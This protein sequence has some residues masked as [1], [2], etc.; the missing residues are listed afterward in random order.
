MLRVAQGRS[1]RA[2]LTD[3]RRSARL[4]SGPY[5]DHRRAAKFSALLFVAREHRFVER[6]L[7]LLAGGARCL[8]QARQGVAASRAESRA[9]ALV[10]FLETGGGEREQIEIAPESRQRIGE[11]N[12]R[13]EIGW[14]GAKAIGEPFDQRLVLV[15]AL[16][17]R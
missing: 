16:D 12:G 1:C 8:R 11:R 6:A 17:N 10:A 15:R 4:D 9:R 3:Q 5:H 13:I 14:I 2:A 7:V